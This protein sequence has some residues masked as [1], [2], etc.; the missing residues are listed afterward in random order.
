[1]SQ[2]LNQHLIT[3]GNDVYD[4]SKMS[5]EEA[6][7]ILWQIGI[8]AP[9]KL[10]EGQKKAYAQMNYAFDNG[11]FLKWFFNWSRRRGKSYMNLVDAIEQGI[12][13]KN[14][15]FK[16][17][18]KTEKQVRDFIL[19]II[20][21][22]TADAPLNVKPIWKKS[23]KILYFPSSGSEM[24]ISGCSNGH[25]ESL[26]G[27]FMHR[28]YLDEAGSIPNMKKVLNDILLP[29][30][31]TLP[32][33]KNGIRKN[34]HVVVSS[35]P[36]DTPAHD[37]FWDCQ[38]AKQQ[39]N[40]TEMNVWTNPRITKEL[41]EQY[42][43]ESGGMD[44]TTWLREYMCQFAT[45]ASKAVIPQWEQVKGRVV[46]E[47]WV[48]PEFYDRYE[49]MDIGFVDLTIVLFSY[50]DFKQ[51]KWV[52]EDEIVMNGT[53]MTTD[54]LAEAIKKKRIE[55]YGEIHKEPHAA[56]MD[57][58]L[59]LQNDLGRKHNLFYQITRKEDKDTHLNHMILEMIAGNVII[60]EKCKTLISHLAAAIWDKRRK[61]FERIDGFGHFDAI[62]AMLY[63]SRV[64]D[65]N[66]NPYPE[67][68]G[69]NP[70]NQ[71]IPK[72]AHN[73]S[74]TGAELAKAFGLLKKRR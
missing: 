15:Q 55:L 8:I 42:A 48:R 9:F 51:A 3:I 68:Y 5:P 37:F 46:R 20:N 17:A 1:M 74:Q 44:S 22:I 26:R 2:K 41:I 24:K 43:K 63:G 71:I 25:E 29:M 7:D 72:K 31:L 12:R 4:L 45:D 47:K 18:A 62:D 60:L 34:G 33:D 59:I 64:V 73:L 40:Y 35:T 49:S 58:D 30:T 11:L 65:K 16:Y 23:D 57:T 54:N 56:V 19:P 67:N 50:Y 32:P 10:D 21:Q 39:G 27:P 53:G 28:G 14:G 69:L 6:R 36:P 38:L 70:F 52:I 13:T 61:S 66:K